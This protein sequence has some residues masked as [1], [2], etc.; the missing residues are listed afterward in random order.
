M[1]AV[2]ADIDKTLYEAVRDEAQRRKVRIKEVV[3]WGFRA[4]LAQVN[5]SAAQKLKP[6][7]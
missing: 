4:Y 7:P 5:P 2:Q 1:H 6:G 3:E